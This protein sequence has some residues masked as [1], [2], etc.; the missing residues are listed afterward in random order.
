MDTTL[1][2]VLFMYTCQHPLQSDGLDNASRGM[3]KVAHIVIRTEI[4]YSLDHFSYK[5]GQ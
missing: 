5:N 2:F 4:V 1:T 3:P